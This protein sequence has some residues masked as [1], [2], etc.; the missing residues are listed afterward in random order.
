MHGEK[1]NDNKMKRKRKKNKG[2]FGFSGL[3][4]FINNKSTFA[5]FYLDFR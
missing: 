5:Y 4:K 2:S 1:E 3:R